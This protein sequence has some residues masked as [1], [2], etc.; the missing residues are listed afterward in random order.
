MAFYIL[1][2]QYLQA[3]LQTQSL[4]C[5]TRIF[6]SPSSLLLFVVGS[7]I[8][9]EKISGSGIKSRI[10]NTDCKGIGSGSIIVGFGSRSAFVA[11]DPDLRLEVKNLSGVFGFS[12]LLLYVSVCE[13]RVDDIITKGTGTKAILV[14][15]NNFCN[16]G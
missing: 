2:L 5:Q 11:M 10:R 1:L 15:P 13:R 14:V 16:T 9:H 3:V 12:A 4:C 7:G 8:L 6:F